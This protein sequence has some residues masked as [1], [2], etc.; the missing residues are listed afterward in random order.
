MFFLFKMAS[1]SWTPPTT[2]RAGRLFFAKRSLPLSFERPGELFF[3]SFLGHP[4]AF[5]EDTTVFAF[6]HSVSTLISTWVS[7]FPP[8]VLKH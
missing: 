5:S 4:A 3:M 8:L 1:K 2:N 7:L 6:H